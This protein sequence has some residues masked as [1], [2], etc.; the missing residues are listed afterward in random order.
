MAD[1]SIPGVSDKYKTNDYIEALM[2]K[3][4]LPLT[5]EQES[6][7]RYKEQQSAW[8]TVNQ[9]MSSLRTNT[10][11]L[12]SFDNPFNNKLA[13]STNEN[14]VTATPGREASYGSIKID[15]IQPATAD[16]FLSGDLDKDFKIP[17]G[18]Y[19]FQVGEKTVSFN[20]KGGKITDFI[21]S[22][23]K[24]GANTIKA[25]IVGVSNDKQSLL[26]ESLKTGSENNLIFKDDALTFALK[27]EMIAKTKADFQEFG[28]TKQDFSSPELE[29]PVPAVEQNG[30]P[31]FTDKEVEWDEEEKRFILP[32]RSGLQLEIDESFLENKNNRIEFTFSTFEVEDI[33][34]ELNIKRTTRPEL[35]E[36]GKVT[37]EDV[38]VWN[39]KTKVELPPPPPVPL[40]PIAGE[41]DFYARTKDG[42]EIQ[43]ETAQL[44]MDSETGEKTVQLDIKD[45]PDIQSIVVRNRNTGEAVALS[46]FQIYDVKKNLGYQ[47]V[48]PVTEAKDAVIKYEGITIT[49]PTNKIDDVVPHVTLNIFNPTEKTETIDIKPD[50][51]SAKDALIAFVGTYNQVIAEMNILSENKPEI[52][53]ELDYLTRDEQE[54]AKKRLGMFQGDSSLRTGKSSMQSI[55]SANYRWSENATVTMLNQ[56]GISTR[57]TGA[58]GGYSPSQMRGYLEINEKQL[59][60]ALEE[61][62]DQI[63]NIFGFDSDGDLIIDQGIGFQLDKQLTSWVQNGGIIANKNT[64]INGRIKASES[65]IA[66][67]EKQLDTK[68][69]QL[70]AKYGQ[71]EGTL[72]S[73]NSQSNTISNFANSGK[74]Q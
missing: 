6:L 43:I 4:R 24:R 70:R 21:N 54:D 46:T 52:I 33:T 3:E 16:R 29:F 26:I 13:S 15:V 38:T 41:A 49:R 58:Q 9:K 23:N 59:D 51:E 31:E 39:D 34:E 32:P 42:K 25:S 12:Y 72:N 63:K 37:Y 68:E 18:K 50:K 67:L 28:M 10:K 55:I 56:I 11:S 35:G 36:A 2:K 5:R 53:S 14:A 60:Q 1:I 66:S 7:D 61:N 30:M 45:Y 57:A 71:M 22:L 74:Q 62:L 65:K 47:A 69:A 20:W 44:A 27:H 64:T 73:L 48:H 19:T 8:N 40:T 17:Q